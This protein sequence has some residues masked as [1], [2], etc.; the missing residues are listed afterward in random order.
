MEEIQKQ[1]E[2]ILPYV[3]EP[4]QY[5]NQEWNSVHKSHQDVAVKVVLAYPD[6]YEVGMPNLGLQILYNIINQEDHLV[7]ERAYAPRVD[8][9]EKLRQ[10]KIPLFSWESKTSLADFDIVGFSLQ[11]EM[12]FTNILTM[13]E[14]ANIDF[15]A[16]KRGADQPLIIGGGPVTFNPEP[17][18]AFFDLF[19]IG[20]G[21]EIILELIEAYRGWK[22]SGSGKKDLLEELVKI[23]GIY[24]PSFYTVEYEE[25]G[26]IEKIQPKLDGYPKAIKRRFIE[27][28]NKAAVPLK[29]VVPFSKVIHDRLSV[30]IMRGCTRGCRFCQAGMIYRPVR[31]RTLDKLKSIIESQ[32]QSTGY[33]EFSLASLSSSDYSGISALLRELA[34]AYTRQGVSISF[35]SL[36]MDSFSIELANQ[37]ARVKKTGLTFAPEAGSQRLRDAINKDITD[38]DIDVTISA[39][40]SSGWRKLKLYFMIGL[41]TETEDDLQGIVDIARR[42]VKL[43]F[44]IIP[45]GERRQFEVVFS[46]SCFTP[47]PC[48]PFQWKAQDSLADLE[49]KQNFLKSQLRMRHTK[50]KW[51]DAKLSWLEGVFARGDRQLAKVIECAWKKGCRFDAWTEHFR[52]DLWMQAFDECGLSPQFYANRERSYHEILPWT[53]INCGVSKEFLWSEHQKALGN[54]KTADCRSAPC[55]EC[56]VC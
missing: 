13:L 9:E 23:P 32:M 47:K 44:S 2:G 38:E 12:T 7:A 6:L 5:I 1:L 33:E 34:Q 41:P 35:P 48:V 29:P 54:E 18:A 10:Y 24:V 40:L 27:D 3:K 43:G 49:Q 37:I 51:H 53:H 55:T 21:E 16:E 52:F 4:A 22:Q 39:A 11:Y 19:V 56:G 36:R 17:L 42:I 28:L 26:K 45:P 50:L 8:L 25:S 31:E 30:E 46:V 20:E 14:L 15:H